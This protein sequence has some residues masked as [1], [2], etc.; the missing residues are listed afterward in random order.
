VVAADIVVGQRA[1]VLRAP[2]Q[3]LQFRPSRH[4][5]LSDPVGARVH[6]PEGSSRVWVLR[7]HKPVALPVWL[8]LSDGVYT[9]IIKGDVHPGDELIVGESKA[10]ADGD[11]GD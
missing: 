11:G 2:I 9:E 7:N 1:N 3:A 10:A 4:V 6:S 5:V 8:G